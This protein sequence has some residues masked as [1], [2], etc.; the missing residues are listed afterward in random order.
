M[1]KILFTFFLCLSVI[2]FSQVNPNDTIRV[3]YHPKD[4]ISI[5]NNN[6]KT[7]ENVVSDLEKANGPTNNTLKLNP[8]RAGLYS[9]VFPGLGQFYNKKYWKVPIVWGAV[10]AGVGIAVWNDN[11]YRKYREYYI[12]KLNGTPN[13][14]VDS[15][16]WLDKVALGNAQDRAKRQRDYAIAGTALIYILNIVDAVV[17]AH[18]YE[19]RKDPDLSF[20]P[21]VIQDQYGI[22][23]PKTGI[24]LSY[25]F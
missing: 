21:S 9:A 10:G 15:H 25:K 4:S 2:A 17:D 11:Q 5:E 1:K 14:F 8:T 6:T 18:L 3:E 22:A 23:P 24:S 12:A 19:S 7:E 16:P 13:E 20:A